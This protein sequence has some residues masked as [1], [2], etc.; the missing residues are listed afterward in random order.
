MLPV[1]LK[2]VPLDT[3]NIIGWDDL[4]NERQKCCVP[5]KH[6]EHVMKETEMNEKPR[7]MFYWKINLHTG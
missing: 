6:R 7:N 3:C 1:T 2:S 4:E 5:Q